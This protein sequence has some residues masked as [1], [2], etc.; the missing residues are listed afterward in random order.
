MLGGG[1]RV[2]ALRPFVI[3]IPNIFFVVVLYNI[4]ELLPFEFL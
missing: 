2:L 3:F 4:Y 1:R